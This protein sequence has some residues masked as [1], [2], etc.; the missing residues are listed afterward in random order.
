V[1]HTVRV[2]GKT[3]LEVTYDKVEVNESLPSE[4][5]GP[6][7][8]IALPPLPEPRQGSTP[9]LPEVTSIADGV[10]F[11]T[12]LGGFNTI[13]P[14]GRTI[15]MTH[16][17]EWLRENQ[18]S[19]KR[20]YGV[21]GPWYGTEEHLNKILAE[22]EQPSEEPFLTKVTNI[23]SSYPFWSPDGT[24]IVFQSNRNDDNS[25]IY[26]MSAN[27]TEI[28]RLTYHTS[29]D[30]TPVWSPD[31]S[32]IAFQT[33][34]DGNREIYSMNPDG[35]GQVNLTRHLA[36]DSHPKFTADGSH[37]IFDSDREDLEKNYEIY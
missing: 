32:K 20:I 15:I 37:I 9:Q 25:E 18:I 17:A 21:H 24:R 1:G 19:P 22:S 30:L 6:P 4:A 36:E 33:D 7:P 14:T 28:T 11:V 5:F 34:R 13:P 35:S 16:F 23:E 12:N 26:V 2:G 27:G 29:E 8:D 3:Y 10:F 31:G